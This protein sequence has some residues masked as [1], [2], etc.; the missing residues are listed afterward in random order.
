MKL[1]ITRHGE[2]DWNALGIIQGRVDRDLN[3]NGIK[4]A[5]KIKEKLKEE[6]I[7]LIICSPLL[8]ARHTAE[9]INEG[10]NIEIITDEDIIE[11][12]FGSFEGC[13]MSQLDNVDFNKNNN[14]PVREVESFENLY[15]RTYRFLDKIKEKYSDK[16]VLIV[17]H[18]GLS[19]PIYTY[20]NGE[21]DQDKLYLCG[22]KNCE[23]R[24]YDL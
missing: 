7:D 13:D 15:K 2:T 21:V 16:T 9:I 17:T 10:R 3:E 8:R 11:R 14:G 22:L 19:I 5:R 24:S 20:F 4:Q 18:G 1:L 6:K 12:D 23:I